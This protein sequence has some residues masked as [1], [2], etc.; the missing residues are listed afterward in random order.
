MRGAGRMLHPVPANIS[1]VAARL[2]RA[3]GRGAMTQA[4]AWARH[5]AETGDAAERAVWRRIAWEVRR[6]SRA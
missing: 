6:L 2:L 5:F 1:A 3:Y 4:M